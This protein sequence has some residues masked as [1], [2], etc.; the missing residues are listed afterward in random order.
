M[1]PRAVLV[2]LPGVGKSTVGARLAERLGVPFADSDDLIVRRAGRSVTAIFDDDGEAAFRELESAVVAEALTGFT[3]VLALGGGAVTTAAVRSGLAG[4]GVPVVLLT[5]PREVLLQRI[6]RTRHR[7]L[8]VA[9]PAGRLAQL[10]AERSDL[11]A[12]VCTVRLDTADRPVDA[13]A[14]ELAELI[15]IAS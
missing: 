3:G 4:S 10:A 1:A 15:G 6:G 5:A 8:L 12:S 2:G 7:P 13:V 11:Y 14:G 9:D